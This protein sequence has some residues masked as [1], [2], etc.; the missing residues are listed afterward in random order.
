MTHAQGQP[1]G[2]NYENLITFRQ[3]L[4]TQG[5]TR[6]RDAQF[7]L[8][9]AL[10]LS[11]PIQSFPQLSLNPVFRRRWPSLYAAL[12]E[13]RQNVEWLEHYLSHQVPW[14]GTHVFAVDESAW[15]HPS[16]NVLPDRQYVQ[17]GN[18]STDGQKLVVGH[19][20]SALTWIAETRSSWALPLSMRRVSS[21]QVAGEVA[22]KQVKQLLATRRAVGG[23]GLNVVVAD[24]RYGNHYFLG[25]LRDEPNCAV[26]VKLRR[27]RVLYGLPGPYTGIG[28]Y[29]VHG[30]RFVFK[31][32]DTWGP[33]AEEVSFED[34]TLG[35]VRLR[36]WHNLHAREDPHTPFT[37]ILAETHLERDQ[38]HPPYWLA[39][40]GPDVPS[41]QQRWQWYTHR[42]PIEP[43][44]RFRKQQLYWTLPAFHHLEACDR[45]TMLVTLAQWQLYL[46][47][48]LV[49]DHPLPW[50]P[51]MQHLTPGRVKQ[52]L[53]GLFS[54]IHT[55]AQP[56]K[57]RGNS[58]GWPSGRPRTRPRRYPVVR[59]GKR[60]RR[61]HPQPA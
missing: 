39:Y 23:N 55:P 28:R 61:P 60:R 20:Y 16:A 33:P 21:S 15:P 3:A 41:L 44:F 19:S 22:V 38:P 54:Q 56:P 1:I 29:P 35:E 8:L 13:G 48:H 12:M 32:P 26:I 51:P 40:L 50:Q 43:S 36:A 37:V 42:W 45:W 24:G 18:P 9:D 6:A 34:E 14:E 5:L 47:R 30:A 27:N 53:A 10:L 46:A 2:K 11:P 4:Y 57:R 59:K 31:N 7:E 25:P 58:P 49:T 52:S 17:S